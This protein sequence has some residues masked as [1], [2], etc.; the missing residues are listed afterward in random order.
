MPPAEGDADLL[1]QVLRNLHENAVKYSPPGSAITTSV[2]ADAQRVT[3][4]VV[5]EGSG[6]APEHLGSVFERFRRPGADPG[7][8]GMGLGL[9]L[10]RHLIEAQGGQISVT[11]PGRGKGATFSLTLPISA[12]WVVDTWP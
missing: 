7:V 6:I 5:D 4:N 11:S 9:Y 8:R 10:S 12:D 1:L 2:C 3:I